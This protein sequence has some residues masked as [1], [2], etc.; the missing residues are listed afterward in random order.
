MAF[1]AASAI[2]AAGLVALV[3]RA[4]VPLT[5]TWSAPTGCPKREAVVA[6]VE[7][8]LAARTKPSSPVTASASITRGAGD[9]H[10]RIVVETPSGGRQRLL[11]APTCAELADAAALILAIAINPS[12]V[13]EQPAPPRDAGAGNDAGPSPDAGA[14]GDAGNPNDAGA[15]AASPSAVASAAPTAR[16]SATPSGTANAPALVEP[17]SSAGPEPIALRAVA[18]VD[19]DQGTFRGATPSFRA[20]LSF[21]RAPLRLEL[22][23]MFTWGGRIPAPTLPDA[24]GEMWRAG[25]SLAACVERALD[26]A[27]PRGPRGG[28]CLGFEAGALRATSYG[29]L[30]PD[31]VTVPWLAP[32]IGALARW[33]LAKRFALRFDVGV[34]APIVEPAFR[35]LGVGIVHYVGLVTARGGVGIEVDLRDTF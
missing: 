4:E 21:V 22:A 13:T 8:L 9:Y 1:S 33:P 16:A 31:Q 25:G 2:A 15:P 17:R 30:S 5:L 3:A 32:S 12:A 29:V 14:A 27:A 11:A 26:G 20:G 28:L 23:G 34:A 10:L 7:R 6:E 18:A 19:L 35:I 24:G